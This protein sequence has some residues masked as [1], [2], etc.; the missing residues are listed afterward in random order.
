[1]V[2]HDEELS[3]WPD[4]LNSLPSKCYNRRFKVIC[5]TLLSSALRIIELL[6]LANDDLDFE[7]NTIKI[8]KTLMWK[9]ANKKFKLKGKSFVK[10]LPRLLQEIG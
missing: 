4:Y 10:L 2:L 6:A 3:I 1:M 9:S 7:D 8:N 5:Q